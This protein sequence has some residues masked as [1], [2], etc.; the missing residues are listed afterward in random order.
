MNE[1]IVSGS[2]DGNII[3]WDYKTGEALI[4]LEEIQSNLQ[5]PVNNLKFHENR[6]YAGL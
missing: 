1:Y 3:V 2:H 4:N 6:L 5:S